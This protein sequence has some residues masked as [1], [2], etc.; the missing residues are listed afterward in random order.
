MFSKFLI[1][2]NLLY[3]KLYRRVLFHLFLHTSHPKK[4][5]VLI[6]LSAFLSGLKLLK[7]SIST[8]DFSNQDRTL[9]VPI[10]SYKNT[11]NNL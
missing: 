3:Q 10:I 4:T 8:N 9:L 7:L 11:P 1:I 2:I 5:N 6:L